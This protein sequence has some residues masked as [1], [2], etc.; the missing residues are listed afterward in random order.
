MRKP[1]AKNQYSPLNPSQGM[2]N[3]GIYLSGQASFFA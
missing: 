2:I 1:H 3:L